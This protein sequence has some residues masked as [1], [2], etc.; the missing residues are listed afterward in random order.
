MTA[1]SPI[2]RAKIRREIEGYL[3]LDMPEQA[4]AALARLG[5]PTG[6]TPHLLY[7]WGEALRAMERYDEAL[8]PLGQAADALPEDIRIRLAMAWCYKRTGRI[9]RAIG[10]LE[11]ALAVEPGE[12]LLR[13][14]LACYWSLVGNR[15]QALYYLSDALAIEPRYRCMIDDEPDFDLLRSDP[16]F[17]TL[18]AEIELA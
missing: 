4:L 16:E 15:E 3:E 11:Q 7:L 1:N 2:R 10:A 5:D 13:Y 8:L 6:F 17:R 9:D 12:A 18:C 14:N